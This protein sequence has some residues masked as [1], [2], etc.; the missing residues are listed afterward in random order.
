M[1]AADD[2][3]LLLAGGKLA[4]SLGSY[5]I[6]KGF[7]YQEVRVTFRLIAVDA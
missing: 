3:D 6:L 5:G 4:Q 7:P 2:H 1:I